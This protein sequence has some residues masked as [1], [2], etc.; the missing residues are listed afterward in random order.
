MIYFL[1]MSCLEGFENNSELVLV[2]SLE[3]TTSIG[4][5]SCY[6]P[7]A[8]SYVLYCTVL[9]CSVPRFPALQFR[10]S[11]VWGGIKHQ[12]QWEEAAPTCLITLE[13]PHIQNWNYYFYS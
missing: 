2:C 3:G 4:T 1:I 10:W 13:N 9:Y 8:Y 11:G 5:L 12:V 6:I 7:A